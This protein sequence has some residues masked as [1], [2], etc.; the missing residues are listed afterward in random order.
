MRALASGRP[1]KARQ[2]WARV[3]EAMM[4]RRSC[5][6]GAKGPRTYDFTNVHLAATPHGL[7]RTLLIRCSTVLNKRNKKGEL[8]REVAYF[9]CHHTPGTTP[10]E[11]PIAAGQRWMIKETFQAAKSDVGFD[12]HEVRK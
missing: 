5:A 3:P 9:L 7:A 8:V 10:A 12:Q 6:D 1:Q 2:L 4:E 11:L